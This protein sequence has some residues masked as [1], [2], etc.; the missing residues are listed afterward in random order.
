M[1]RLNMSEEVSSLDVAIHQGEK[2]GKR[3]KIE[4]R[5]EIGRGPYLVTISI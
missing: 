3:R 4:K 2:Y 5:R 1:S